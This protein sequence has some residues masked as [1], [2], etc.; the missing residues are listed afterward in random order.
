MG[1]A[2]R[3]KLKMSFVRLGQKGI[4]GQFGINRIGNLNETISCGRSM[5]DVYCV[6]V[7]VMYRDHRGRKIGLNGAIHLLLQDGFGTVKCRLCRWQANT[8]HKLK[9]CLCIANCNENTYL[10]DSHVGHYIRHPPS[11]PAH[12]THAAR[13]LLLLLFIGY[14]LMSF[15]M[16]ACVCVI[17]VCV[18][19]M[20]W[21]HRRRRRRR[22]R[23]RFNRTLHSCSASNFRF[24]GSFRCELWIMA[25]ITPFW[26]IR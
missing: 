23:R 7:R 21:P 19:R 8:I 17:C 2:R 9:L 18:S 24:V 4:F 16:C 10:N 1:S 20:L 22:T 5:A 12:L 26:L 25:F 14:I 6:M 15:V 3:E 11:A 13:I